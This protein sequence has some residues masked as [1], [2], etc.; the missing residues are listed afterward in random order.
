MA[1][2]SKPITQYTRFLLTAALLMIAT[3]VSAYEVFV[4][5]GTSHL[6]SHPG[7][8]AGGAHVSAVPADITAA[9]ARGIS[10]M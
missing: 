7:A 10:R 2:K 1:T 8:G 4:D 6:V 9:C 3:T 5:R